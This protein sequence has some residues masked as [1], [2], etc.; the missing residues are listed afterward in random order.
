MEGFQHR[1]GCLR[2]LYEPEGAMLLWV[3]L[4]GID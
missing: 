2:V 4:M 1:G 3:T